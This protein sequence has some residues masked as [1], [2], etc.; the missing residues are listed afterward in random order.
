VEGTPEDWANESRGV[1]Y[2]L[3]Y[4]SVAA[5]GPPPH[6]TPQYVHQ[7]TSDARQQLQRAGMRL[8][9]VLNTALR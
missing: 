1:A 3:A 5:D 4:L 9:I 7:A 6:L 2:L 8:A